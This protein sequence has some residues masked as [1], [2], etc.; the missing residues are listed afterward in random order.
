M[1]SNPVANTVLFW[2][3]L[4]WDS[5]AH[6]ALSTTVFLPSF[7]GC[8][9]KLCL[10]CWTAFLV[11]SFKVFHIYPKNLTWF[12]DSNS[13]IPNS[14]FRL[15]YFSPVIKHDQDNFKRK[16]WGLLFQRVSVH[17]G[18]WRPGGGASESSHP[19]SNQ[20]GGRAHWEWHVFWHLRTY[21]SNKAILPNPFYTGIKQSIIWAHDSHPHSKDHM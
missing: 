16:S 10:Q 20:E 7:V 9:L 19:D 1:V 11:Q 18:E 21:P 14:N 17:D 13:P 4:S 5:T 15:R 8:P 3:F 2:N 6:K 12:C